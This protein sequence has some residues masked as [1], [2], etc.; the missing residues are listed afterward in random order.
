MVAL[1]LLSVAFGASK[2]QAAPC[3]T[4][5]LVLLH[6]MT[7][8]IG[9]GAENRNGGAATVVG[10]GRRIEGP[11]GALLHCFIGA[12]ARDHRRGR[13]HYCHLLAARAAVATGIGGLPGSCRIKGAAAMTG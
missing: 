11:G 3:S 4:V 12:A 8:H 9:H 6:V 7:G 13:V 2:V 5:L 10:S 1:P